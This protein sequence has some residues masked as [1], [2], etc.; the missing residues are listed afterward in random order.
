VESRLKGVFATKPNQSADAFIQRCR[1]RISRTGQG[2]PEWRL[3]AREALIRAFRS[4]RTETSVEFGYE[5]ADTGE[6]RY[7]TSYIYLAQNPRSG[8]V[9]ALVCMLDTTD[10]TRSRQ[11][12]SRISEDDYDYFA[13]LDVKKRTVRFLRIRERD[14]RT[15]PTVSQD[16]DTDIR[17]A[18]SKLMGPEESARC[19]DALLLDRVLREL[20]AG[21]LYFSLHHRVPGEPLQ[22]KQLRYEWLDESREQILLTRMDITRAF[23]REQE[24]VGAWPTP[25]AR[26]SAPTRPN[27][28]FFPA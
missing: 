27:P 12:M 5:A 11:I 23:L 2:T 13:L 9:E 1:A 16:Y 15:T 3:L 20:A 22:K 10:D 18:F 28:I 8:S 6:L 14:R 24:Q 25:C 4:G 26:R 19:V 17:Y 21:H 7:A